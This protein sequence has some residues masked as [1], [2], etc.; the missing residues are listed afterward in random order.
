MIRWSNHK[1]A[2]PKLVEGIECQA[3]SPKVA[4]WKENSVYECGKHGRFDVDS[5]G[6]VRWWGRSPR[7]K[8]GR[9]P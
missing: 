5:F 3:M 4:V 7:G 9:L 1:V 6:A 8:W 2:C